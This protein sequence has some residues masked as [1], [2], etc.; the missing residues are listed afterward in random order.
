M[1]E[2]DIKRFGDEQF[3]VVLDQHNQVIQYCG[4]GL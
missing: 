3:A 1:Y 4:L 2:E